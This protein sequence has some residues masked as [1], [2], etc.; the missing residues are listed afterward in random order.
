VPGQYSFLQF[1]FTTAP[2][3]AGPWMFQLMQTPTGSLSGIGESD[4]T[5]RGQ[6]DVKIFQF[7]TYNGLVIRGPG[8]AVVP[9]GPFAAML[10]F[11]V[12]SQ[13]KTC[14]T[15]SLKVPTLGSSNPVQTEPHAQAE[16][17]RVKTTTVTLLKTVHKS[18]G[19]PW[20]L[21]IP[22]GTAGM[23]GGALYLDERRRRECAEDDDDDGDND[24]EGGEGFGGAIVGPQTFVDTGEHPV[25]QPE[26]YADTKV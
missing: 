25:V 19:P 2:Q 7:G 13:P 4:K 21:A 1:F 3:Y 14:D 17:P 12:T 22:V 20:S 11:T 16:A 5:G 24:G 26:K 15:N 23:L 9:N 8:N 10:P 6:V 18:A